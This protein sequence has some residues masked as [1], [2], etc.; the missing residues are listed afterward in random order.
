MLENSPVKLF[1]M[2]ARTEKYHDVFFA[3]CNR[4]LSSSNLVLGE[5]NQNLNQLLEII[6]G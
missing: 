6:L 1:D 5:E 3:T 4:V 2:K